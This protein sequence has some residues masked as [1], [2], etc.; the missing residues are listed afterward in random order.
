MKFKF[1]SLSLLSLSAVS[2]FL[3]PE[4]TPKAMAGCV[5]VDVSTQVA[6]DGTRKTPGRQTN[7]VSQ[8]FGENC[9]GSTVTSVGNQV[10]VATNCEAQ[11]RSSTQYVSG[12]SNITG[13]KTPNINVKVHVPVHVYNPAADPNFMNNRRR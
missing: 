3:M 13:V 7:Q 11:R 6:I 4:W 9:L 10:C 1:L 5:A 2:P 12:G 8:S